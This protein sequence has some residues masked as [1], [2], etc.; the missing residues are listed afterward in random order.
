MRYYLL[1]V[2]ASMIGFGARLIYRQ[3][4]FLLRTKKTSGK[5]N[6]WIEVP[7]LNSTEVYYYAEVVFAAADGTEYRVKGNAGS[8]PKPRTPIGHVIP[9]RYDPSNPNDAQFDSLFQLW[10]APAAFVLLGG[11]ATAVFFHLLPGNYR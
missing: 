6:R 10:S 2:G 7:K 4:T 5:L 3:I 9:I 1:I 11:A 8:S